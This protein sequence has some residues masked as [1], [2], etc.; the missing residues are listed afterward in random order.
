MANNIYVSS[1]GYTAVPVW[2][3]GT[4]YSAA[5]NGGRG[6]YVRQLAAPAAG[7][8]RVFRC[9][10]GG[11]SHASTE[12]TWTL[13]KNGTT[14]DNTV[15]WTECTGQEA[16]QASNA[17]KAPHARLR[18]ALAATWGA[19]GDK[20][21]VSQDHAE[22]EAAVLTLTFP[23]T[24]ASPNELYC[25]NRGV[26]STVP[27]VSADLRT[28]T[29]I[30]NT[31]SNGQTHVGVCLP[32][33]GVTFNVGNSASPS[34][35]QGGASATDLMLENCK[36]V[37]TGNGSVI[38]GATNN[39][40]P[41]R[42]RWVNTQVQF[43]GA[44]GTIIPTGNEFTWRDTPNAV[45]GTIPTTLLGTAAGGD[46]FILFDGVDLGAM[47][48]G[49]TIVGAFGKS[50]NITLKD[51][52]LG[53]AKVADE[54]AFTSAAQ[55]VYVVRSDS[56]GTNYRS[57]FYGYAGKQTTTSTVVRTGSAAT[58]TSVIVAWRLATTANAKRYLS[59]QP[60]FN[61]IWNTVTNANVTVTMYGVYVGAALPKNDEVW[62]DVSYCGSSAT[63]Q[64]T[65]KYG[66]PVDGL[67]AGS[68]W[69]ADTSAWDSAAP[70]RANS[71][72]YVVGDAVKVASN[73]NRVFFVESIAGTG[74]TAG[75][76]PAGF[77]TAVDGDQITD[78]AGG[79]QVV[80]RCGVR[81]KMSVVLTSPQ[82]QIPGEIYCYVH[83]G[84]ASAVYYVDPSPVLS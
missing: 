7:S 22:T 23:G 6:D 28:T 2:A 69:T 56:L 51:C 26:G 39:N 73:P 44:T 25:V 37:L 50:G 31:G 20:F 55:R 79:N 76:E 70:A 81:F 68:N 11:T 4:A 65:F 54:T 59:L 38:P 29:A 82:P 18:N 40:I 41:Q 5:S 21:F 63:P 61:A 19:A 27:P 58:D 49:K 32:L 78:N 57:E 52:K 3:V 67:T 42:V 1:V 77:A 71:T 47:G 14:A 16:E 9:T 64:A 46:G 60:G 34:C 17:W 15:V 80:W 74:T 75:S 13:T 72:A 36:F 24:E 35:T 12:P 83:A 84:K 48:S 10:T 8:E 30:S 43:A 45:L 66:K 62:F 53:A 33:Y